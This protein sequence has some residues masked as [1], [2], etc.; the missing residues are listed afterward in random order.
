MLFFVFVKILLNYFHKRGRVSMVLTRFFGLH[1]KSLVIIKTR[2]AG[3]GEVEGGGNVGFSGLAHKMSTNP[4]S[5][6]LSV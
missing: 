6:Y 3:T 1:M 2:E 5:E 4:T